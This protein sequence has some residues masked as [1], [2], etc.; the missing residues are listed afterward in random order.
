MSQR[1]MG[2]NIVQESQGLCSQGRGARVQ[3]R[4]VDRHRQQFDL[5]GRPRLEVG[6]A[7]TF[8]YPTYQT[9]LAGVL[10]E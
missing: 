2:W 5:M 8:H 10:F 9:N 3:V 7:M 6:V 4:G 1:E